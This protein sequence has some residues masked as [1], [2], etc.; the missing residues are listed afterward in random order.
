MACVTTASFQVLW[1]GGLTESFKP[2][3]GLRQGC[4]LPPICLL[5]VLSS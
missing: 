4:P 5:F 3:R 1:N 2:T